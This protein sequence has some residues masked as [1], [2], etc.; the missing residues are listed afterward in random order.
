[1]FIVSCFN[2]NLICIV[3]SY[4]IAVSLNQNVMSRLQY[5]YNVTDN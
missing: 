1:M 2:K 4:A 5:E 3:Y